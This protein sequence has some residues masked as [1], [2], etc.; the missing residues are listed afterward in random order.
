MSDRK[1]RTA[2]VIGTGMMGP[3]IAV[4]LALGGLKTTILSRTQEGAEQGLAKALEQL[5]VRADNGLD[6][7]SAAAAARDLLAAS[8]DLDA[9]VADADIVIESAPEDMAFK[10]ELFE[11]L[12]AVARPDAVLATNTSGLSIGEVGKRCKHRDRVLTTHFWNP[13]YL[14]RLVEI[15]RSEATSDEVVDSVKSLL[16]A[17]GKAVVM[18]NKDVP[19]QLGNRLQHAMIREALHIV[20]EGI[21]SVEDVDLA[22][23]EGYGMRLP[24]YGIFEHADACGLDL[25]LSIQDYVDQDLY[26]ETKAP[27][28][29]REL[30]EKGDLGVKTG[31]G[32]Y[33]WSKKNWDQV[34]E[35]RDGFILEFLKSEFGRTNL[36]R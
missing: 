9:V 26:S 31:K 29:I 16:E 34:R 3:G 11:R 23:K 14:M 7:A 33:D 6:E 2:A 27:R 8:T 22:A 28:S 35:R 12:D 21:A 5:T 32:F 19:G 18:V 36:D 25:V 13:P 24:V 10:Q 17:C 30:H 15:V 1:F 4:S 20:A